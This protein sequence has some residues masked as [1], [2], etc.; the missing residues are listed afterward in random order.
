MGFIQEWA[1][2]LTL[3]TLLSLSIIQK[4]KSA[5]CRQLSTFHQERIEILNMSHIQV[6]LP[7]S[8]M[9]TGCPTNY[10][11]NFYKRRYPKIE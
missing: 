6:K 1:I 3:L 8:Y 10:P 5:L 9:L 2:G 11:Q 4:Q 7:K